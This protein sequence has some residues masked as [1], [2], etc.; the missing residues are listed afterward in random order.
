MRMSEYLFRS[1][2]MQKCV[3]TAD[4]LKERQVSGIPS[5]W[6]ENFKQNIFK[7]SIYL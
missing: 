4:A 6:K 1:R 2:L 5:W 7:G 3:G